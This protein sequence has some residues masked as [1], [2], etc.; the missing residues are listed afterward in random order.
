MS[1]LDLP[2]PPL[3]RK[4]VVTENSSFGYVDIFDIMLTAV[5]PIRVSM[6]TLN[7]DEFV[8]GT[9]AFNTSWSIRNAAIRLLRKRDRALKRT[10]Y[11]GNY[12]RKDGQ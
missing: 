5:R 3:G 4:W 11:L 8:Y 9:T 6:R 10:R 1:N 2:E 12:A 7:E